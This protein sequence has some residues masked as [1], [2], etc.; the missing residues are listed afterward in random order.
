VPIAA[1][2]PPLL[3]ED[4]SFAWADGRLALDGCSLCVP[5][6]GLWM[7]VGSNGSGKSTLLRLI[8][9]LIAPRSGQIRN[10]A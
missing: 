1:V 6:P 2:E 9:G 5:G 7:L 3:V 8:A 4:L 10:T